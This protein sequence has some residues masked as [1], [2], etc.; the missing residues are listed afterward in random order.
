MIK[1]A[2]D[3]TSQTSLHDYFDRIHSI[4]QLTRKLVF[5]QN[6]Y[7]DFYR[8]KIQKVLCIIQKI[9]DSYS[10]MTLPQFAI[11]IVFL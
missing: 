8:P 3:I 2:L 11:L 4:R 7:T 6:T 10:G 5:N 9:H 1:Q